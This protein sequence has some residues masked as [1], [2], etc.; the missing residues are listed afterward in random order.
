MASWKGFDQKSGGVATNIGVHFYD[1]LGFIFGELKANHV[2]YRSED[3]S[4]GYLE[5]ARARVRWVL[6][7]NRAHLPDRTPE[8]QT[9]FRSI[10]VDGTEI[11]F[12]GGFTDLHTMSYQEVLKGN[13]FGLDAV[14]P[15]IEIVSAIRTMDLEPGKGEAHPDLA[16]ITKNG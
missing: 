4:A 9:T 11:E 8:G 5:F 7:I 15:S 14:R 6:S 10:T 13:G 3:S 2:H 1:M 12:S 16:R